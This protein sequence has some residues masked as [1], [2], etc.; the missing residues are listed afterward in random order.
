M[1]GKSP[2]GSR[3]FL[4]DSHK[5]LNDREKIQYSF[6]LSSFLPPVFLSFSRLRY[7]YEK[8]SLSLIQKLSNDEMLTTRENSLEKK[9]KH[10]QA[11]NLFINNF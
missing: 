10:V 5:I 2:T 8:S 9:K 7:F 4:L 11:F 3:H 1:R 6:S